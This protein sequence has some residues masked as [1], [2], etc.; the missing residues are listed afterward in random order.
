[1]ALLVDLCLAPPAGYTP[2]GGRGSRHSRVARVGQPPPSLRRG[3]QPA[4]RR[5]LL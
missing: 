2:M 1:M 5:D 3:H 4:R